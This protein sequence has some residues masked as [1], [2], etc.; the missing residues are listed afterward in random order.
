MTLNPG[1]FRVVFASG[2]HRDDPR[3]ELHT[4]F[5]LSS[6]GEFLALVDPAG[7]VVHAFSP[8]FPG[9]S[10]TSPAAFPRAA[11]RRCSSLRGSRHHPRSIER[12]ARL[13]LDRNRF[14]DSGWTSGT[15]G[16]GYDLGTD[17]GSLI[18]TDIEGAMR[19]VNSSAYVRIPFNVTDPAAWTPSSCESSTT[20][21]SWISERPGV[22][23]A[24]RAGRHPQW[25]WAATGAHGQPITGS[26][27]QNFRRCGDRLTS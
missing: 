20:T 17:Y 6:D 14:D 25:N 23:A 10:R 18:G 24:Q 15:T 5:K 1:E 2:K 7:T 12:R 3:Y 8:A 22:G 27:S 26:V 11:R 19:G 21:A 13:E 16:V 4:N 9:S